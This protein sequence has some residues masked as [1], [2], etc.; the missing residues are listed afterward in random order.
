MGTLARIRTGHSGNLLERAADVVMKQKKRLILCPRETPLSALHLENMTYLA[1]LGVDIVPPMPAFYQKPK[2]MCGLVDF[3]VG[4]VIE[5]L[6][7]EHDL[8]EPWNRR[9]R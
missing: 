4:R 1:K 7:L 9:M 6:D 2:D 3:V 5:Q 8:Y